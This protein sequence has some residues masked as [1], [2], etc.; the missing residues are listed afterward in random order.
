MA[1]TSVGVL[2]K[3]VPNMNPSICTSHRS[4]SYH[5]GIRFC[6]NSRDIS[7]PCQGPFNLSLDDVYTTFVLLE[8]F[9]FILPTFKC[10]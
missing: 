5:F 6:H 10:A 3:I 2:Y 1:L 4:N 7:I 8:Q 9:Q